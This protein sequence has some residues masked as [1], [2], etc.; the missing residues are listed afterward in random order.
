MDLQEQNLELSRHW[1]TLYNED[2]DRMVLECYAPDCVVSP[3]GGDSIQ[4]HEVLRKVEAAISKAAPRRVMRVEQRHVAGDA[5]IVEAVLR[6]P[7]QGADWQIPFVA[8]L[9]C[10]D[11]RIINDRTYADWSRWPGLG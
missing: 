5:V 9:T 7:D 4:G 1:E 6:D 8:V 3:M 10:K 2:A 11:G